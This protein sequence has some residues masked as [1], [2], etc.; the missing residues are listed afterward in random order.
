[1]VQSL[2]NLPALLL[3]VS[4]GEGKRETWELKV[5]CV[6]VDCYFLSRI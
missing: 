1:M 5:L 6:C 2:S 4:L 3:L